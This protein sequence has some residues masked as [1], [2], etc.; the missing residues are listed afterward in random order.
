MCSAARPEWEGSSASAAVRPSRK[1][2][3]AVGRPARSGLSQADA[4]KPQPVAC[5]LVDDDRIQVVH[6]RVPV[7]VERPCGRLGQRRGDLRQLRLD[8]L[9]ERRAPEGV[10][11]AAA[12]VEVGVDEALGDGPMCELNDREDGACAPARVR[13]R[14]RGEPD[15]LV[16]VGAPGRRA[17]IALDELGARILLP[18]D[19][20]SRLGHNLSN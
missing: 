19:L 1:T 13:G 9:V 15:Q 3:T 2:S 7:A 8:A 20:E 11:G 10:P 12:V 4:R 17:G 14:R 16:D 5:D 18:D 6:G